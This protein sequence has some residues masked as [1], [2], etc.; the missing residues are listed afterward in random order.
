[1]ENKGT[2]RCKNQ[3]GNKNE[4]SGENERKGSREYNGN[5]EMLKPPVLRQ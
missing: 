1:L 5:A 3:Q 4:K 2:S